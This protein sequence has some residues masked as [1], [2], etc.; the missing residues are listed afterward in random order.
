MMGK[1]FLILSLLLL[2]AAW[3]VAEDH[4]STRD[5]AVL[6]LAYS[7]L[8]KEEFNACL[9]TLSPLLKRRPPSSW[10]LAYAALASG[11][12]NRPD[13][14]VAFLSQGT[15][16]YPE[17]RNFWHNLGVYQIQ[18]QKF[19][20]AVKTYKTVIAMEGEMA[21]SSNFYHLCF[22]LYHLEQ[23]DE[24]LAVIK[25][26]T[27]GPNIK[28]QYLQ[29]QLYCQIALEKWTDC[30]G[31]VKQ[32]IRLDPSGA[33]NW[34]LLGQIAVNQKDYDLACAALD[35]KHF[36]DGS[37]GS[38]R[39]LERLY[40]VQSAWN[41]VGRLQG[42]ENNYLGA[43]SLFRAGQYE[44]A[45]WLLDKD[46]ARYM[47]KT[48]LRGTLL[49]ALGKN[50][51]A[52]K[53]LM[54]MDDQE[55]RF[56]DGGDTSQNQ[57]GLKEKRRLKDRLKAGALLLAGQI[58]WMDRNWVK[59]RDMFKKLER[60]PAQANIGR[61]LAACMQFYLDEARAGED[62]PGPYDPALMIEG[63]GNPN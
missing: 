44:K 3:T 40:R 21:G 48:Y 57:L 13:Q 36:L 61:S 39:N 35:I 47:E 27:R 28:K 34:D 4:V 63:A 14:A 41:E 52:V 24:A 38:D 18:G 8:Q 9:Y 11:G 32:L 55:P 53:T 56:L 33:R 54:E 45:L 49:C 29:L 22:A 59:A 62:F 37:P 15:R 12:L 26:I 25:K 16:F 46:P 51:E 6:K 58:Y 2:P 43:Q 30:Q 5:Y 10:A 1:V 60:L 20:A 31:T 42:P 50:A 19:S 7:Q 17:N 23:Y